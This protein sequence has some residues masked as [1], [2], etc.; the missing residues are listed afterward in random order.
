[1]KFQRFLYNVQI[2]QLSVAKYEK[3][4][5]VIMLVAEN[6]GEAVKGY[7]KLSF[8][9]QDDYIEW[10]DS[11]IGDRDD[12][13]ADAAIVRDVLVIMK[14]KADQ[15]QADKRYVS[16]VVRKQVVMNPEKHDEAALLAAI[17]NDNMDFSNRCKQLLA[18]H[19]SIY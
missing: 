1:M 17:N 7:A 16:K 8:N 19:Y 9:S 10:I 6:E 12:V 13:S 15:A 4:D 2:G 5:G 14:A 11:I 3:K 18:E